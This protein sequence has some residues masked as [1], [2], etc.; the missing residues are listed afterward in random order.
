MSEDTNASDLILYGASQHGETRPCDSGTRDQ[1]DVGSRD[2]AKR[3]QR[4]VS[5]ASGPLPGVRTLKLG[6]VVVVG[7]NRTE[8]E[9]RRKDEGRG[10][11]WWV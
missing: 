6:G 1:K 5:V 8:R 10:E 11:H 9:R 7:W 2:G 4:R 3:V